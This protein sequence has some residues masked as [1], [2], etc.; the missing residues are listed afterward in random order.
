[1]HRAGAQLGICWIRPRI[2]MPYGGRSPMGDQAH[3]S[4]PSPVCA[5]SGSTTLLLPHAPRIGSCH[6]SPVCSWWD[7]IAHPIAAGEIPGAGPCHLAHRD[8]EEGCSVNC[9]W[10]WSLNFQT[11]GEPWRLDHMALPM[12]CGL[13]ILDINC[14]FEV[15]GKTVSIQFFFISWINCSKFEWD[16]CL[17]SS[18]LSCAV[19][20]VCSMTYLKA[21]FPAT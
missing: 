11:L 1:M 7:P 12:G 9:H 18:H 13:S 17:F 19:E 20:V 5:G 16:L 3:C 14:Y 15:N 2:P 8:G 4:A 21:G 6:L 10:S